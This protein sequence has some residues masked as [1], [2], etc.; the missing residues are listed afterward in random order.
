MDPR[1]GQIGFRGTWGTKKSPQ[2]GEEK[3]QERAKMAQ[4]G[5]K[6]AHLEALGAD[7]GGKLKEH[8]VTIGAKIRK[9]RKRRI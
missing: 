5:P 3:R 1:S 2:G 4:E 7:F 6:E 8:W 9:C